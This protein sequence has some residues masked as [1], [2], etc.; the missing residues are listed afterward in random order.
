MERRGIQML[1]ND[2]WT[3][4]TILC[5][6]AIMVTLWIEWKGYDEEGKK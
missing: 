6:G 3:D 2:Y 4:L 1:T 5:L